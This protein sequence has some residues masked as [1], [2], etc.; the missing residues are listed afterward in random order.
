[1]VLAAVGLYRVPDFSVSQRPREIG[2]RITLGTQN[3][4]IVK[5]VTFAIFAAVAFGAAAPAL[6]RA[7]RTN[8]VEMLRA[9]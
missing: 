8:P 6:V 1:V 3:R 5:E 7:R 9:D 4:H 2:L